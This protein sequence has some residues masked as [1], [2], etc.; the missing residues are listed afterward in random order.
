M[1]IIITKIIKYRGCPIYVRK[2]GNVFEFLIIYKNKIH[3]SHI[4]SV[5][6][7]YRVFMDEPYTEE[8]IRGTTI[9]LI[10]T[11]KKVIDKLKNNLKK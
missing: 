1:K 3:T 7:L 11:A 9:I 8:E 10:K 4:V 2:F 5:P 6:Q